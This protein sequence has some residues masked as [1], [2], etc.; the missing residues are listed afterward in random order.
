MFIDKHFGDSVLVQT[1][2]DEFALLVTY[3]TITAS[4]HYQGQVWIIVV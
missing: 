2:E 3:I 4:D 1:G